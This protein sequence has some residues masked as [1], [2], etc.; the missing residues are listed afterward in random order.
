MWQIWLIIAGACIIMEMLTVGFLIFWFALGALI[1]MIFSL[2]I[3]SFVIQFTIFIISST[4][5]LFTTK[6]FVEKFQKSNSD[7]KISSSSI[8]GDQGIVTK[9]INPIKGTGQIKINTE[10]WSAKSIDNNVIPEGAN[11][12]VEKIEGVKAIVKQIN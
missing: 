9:E 7:Q 2:F 3:K 11:I 6:P 5:L 10:I 4:I 8:E 1:A 12:I